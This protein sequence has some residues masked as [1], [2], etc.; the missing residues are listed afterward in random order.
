M[1]ARFAC[2]SL[3]QLT[4]LLICLAKLENVQ[5]IS[6]GSARHQLQ[7]RK[8]AAAMNSDENT[9]L[10]KTVLTSQADQCAP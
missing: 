8:A 2:L 7:E 5:P 10:T 9:D 3:L 1:Q 6:S 4:D